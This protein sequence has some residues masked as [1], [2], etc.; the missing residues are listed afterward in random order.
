VLC[1]ADEI[2]YEKE[3]AHVHYQ[4]P[5]LT[6]AD[7][8]ASLDSAVN[9]VK[10]SVS[11]PENNVI[12]HEALRSR[13]GSFSYISTGVAG[14]YHIC[15]E[16]SES[17]ASKAPKLIVEMESGPNIDYNKLQTK[18]DLSKV[19]QALQDLKGQMQEVREEM[20]YVISRQIP[21]QRTSESTF[22]RVWVW[23][24]VQAGILVVMATWQVASLKNFFLAKKLV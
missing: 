13:E 17:F 14:E 4:L 22:R 3:P 5:D 10:V 20:Q 15:F 19:E 7:K 23:S 8:V 9:F 24:S 1:F 11:D 21:F 16:P 2:G 18:E 12:H 6:P